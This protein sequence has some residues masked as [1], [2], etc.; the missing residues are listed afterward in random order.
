MQLRSAKA[1]IEV[2][3][4]D[5]EPQAVKYFQK[6]FSS[7]YHIVTATSADEAED[8]IYS[9]AHEI[10]V[11]ITDQRMPGRSGISLLSS[12]RAKRPD[13]VR[14]LTTAYSDLDSAIQAVNR[15]EI[16]RYVTK[17][18]D[19]ES[20]EADLEQA[21][22]YYLLKQE[23]DH[24]LREKMGAIQRSLLR[25]RVNAMAV[26]STM[27]PAYKNATA[28]IHG[29]LMDTLA[30][31]AWRPA[32]KRQWTELANKDHWRLPVEEAQRLIGIATDLN[33]T[34][35][36]E[37][38]ASGDAANVVDVLED[39][40]ANLRRAHSVMAI[41][42]QSET[43]KSIAA[44]DPAA[45]KNIMSRF[46]EPMSTWAAPGSVLVA[47]VSDIG[48]PEN[49]TATVVDFEMRNFDAAKAAGDSILHAPPY[50][51]TPRIAIEYLRAALALGHLGG[52]V[53]SPPAANGFKQV[54]VVL[55]A[56]GA[57]IRTDDLSAD[58]LDDI[59]D[60]YDRW[61]LGMFDLAS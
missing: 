47:R 59:N 10:G 31:T 4:V 25:D 23:Y 49:P 12:I 20:L 61:M 13:I 11:V 56:A 60:E 43:G 52:K 7:N 21:T 48:K 9:S 46:M 58:W 18:W 26:M 36:I 17:P 2:L 1:P 30:E 22:N 29:Y 44:I 54:Q 14:I 15:G 5:D 8:L 51:M 3:I 27:L 33:D 39:C 41:S 40:A 55:P 24:L 53:S 19:L 42:V 38:L 50:N 45:L 32:V 6:A 16:F 28:T 37:G 35:L 57:A 34:S